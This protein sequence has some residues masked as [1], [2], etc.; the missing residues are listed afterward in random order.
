MT[1]YSDAGWAGCRDTR[2][3]T[4]GGCIQIGFHCIKGW[5]KTQILIALSSGES[6][7]FAA[8]KASAETLGSLPM[9]EYLGWRLN[10]EAWV[11]ANVALGITNRNGLGEIRHISTG[12]LWIQQVAAEQRFTF[13]TALRKCSRNIL[14]NLQIF[15]TQR[16]W[17]QVVEG[18]PEEAP[19]LH[20]ISI[21]LDECQNGGNSQ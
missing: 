16:M 2:K 3:S 4:I 18:R 13:G 12:L 9:L 1:I 17:Y 11:D 5:S 19:D 15:I 6:D 20:T 21:S 10:G 7:W 8:L 14:M